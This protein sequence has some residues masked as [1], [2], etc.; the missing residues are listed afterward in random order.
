MKDCRDCKYKKCPLSKEPCLSCANGSKWKAKVDKTELVEL[1]ENVA[2]AIEQ[3]PLFVN[4][5]DVC[6]S[7]NRCNEEE[8]KICT[9]CCY[10][11]G[12]KF[13]ME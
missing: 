12:S 7:R 6:K 8:L 1:K 2:K 9:S 3:F 5:C 13:E 10:Y 4:P 11:Y